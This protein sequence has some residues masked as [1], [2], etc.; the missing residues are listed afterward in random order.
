MNKKCY[1][2][3]TSVWGLEYANVERVGIFGRTEMENELSIEKT[4]IE[5]KFIELLLRS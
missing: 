3:I 1:D 2:L 5:N 4:H